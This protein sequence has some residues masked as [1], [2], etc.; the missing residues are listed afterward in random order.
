LNLDLT[1][2]TVNAIHRKFCILVGCGTVSLCWSLGKQPAT[3]NV[4]DTL[5]HKGA[6]RNKV[7]ALKYLDIRTKELEPHSTYSNVFSTFLKYNQLSAS[8]AL[9]A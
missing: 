4:G 8:S 3:R 7:E 2:A 1:L 5:V 9:A 6:N